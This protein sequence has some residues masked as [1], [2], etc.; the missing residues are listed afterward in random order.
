MSES[1]KEPSV[2]DQRQTGPVVEAVENDQAG[3]APLGTEGA[4]SPTGA[5]FQS[6]PFEPPSKQPE[7]LN[8]VVLAY[9]G[10]AVFELLVRQH[11]VAGEKLKPNQL[12]RAATSIVCAKAQRRWLELWSPM[13]SEEEQDVVRRGRNTKSGQPPRNADPHDY[14]LATAMECL[15]G[16]LYYKGRTERIRELTAVVFATVDEDRQKETK[17]GQ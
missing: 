9:T 14:R 11:L 2:E 4:A 5:V 1:A 15:I 7:F 10:D 3:P 12:H 8:P 13:L 6:L 16:F 17:H